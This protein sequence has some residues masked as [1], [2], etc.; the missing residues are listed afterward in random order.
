MQKKLFHARDKVIVLFEKRVFS[1]EGNVFKTKE[2]KNQ[3][4]N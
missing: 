2:K 3:E 4:K 1:Y